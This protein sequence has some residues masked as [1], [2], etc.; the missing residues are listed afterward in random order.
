MK[1]KLMPLSKERGNVIH[2]LRKEN[3]VIGVYAENT[4]DW[5]ERLNE[6]KYYKEN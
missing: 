1:K 4:M 6:R 3:V 2:L 5:M